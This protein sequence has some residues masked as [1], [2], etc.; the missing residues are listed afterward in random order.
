LLKVELDWVKKNLPRCV[1]AKRGLIE[2]DHPQLSVRR[3]C[4]LIGLSRAS[5]Y[6]E[7]TPESAENLALMRLIDGQ[8]TKCPFGPQRYHPST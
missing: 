8:Y 6:Y 5:L 7:P 4:E 1:E 2:E 3:Q